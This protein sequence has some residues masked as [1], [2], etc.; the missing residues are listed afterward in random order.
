MDKTTDP[1]QLGVYNHELTKLQTKIDG[2]LTKG[3][4][5]GVASTSAAV[6][7][8]GGKVKRTKQ[9]WD[10]LGNSINQLTRELPAFANFCSNR[11][12]SYF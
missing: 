3:A 12:F 2:L 1:T 8:Q 7:H 4:A 11:F 10:G 6:E 9:H 5:Q